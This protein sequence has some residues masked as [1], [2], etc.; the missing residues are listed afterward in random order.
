MKERKRTHNSVENSGLSSVEARLQQQRYGR[1]ILTSA[2]KNHLLTSLF[3][4]VREPMFLLLAVACGLYFFLGDTT[5][6]IMMLVS[7]A[8]VAGIELFQETKSEKAME[9]LREYTE[10]NVRVLRDNVWVEL[11]AAELVPDDLVTIGEG[12]RVP[13]DG[14]ILKQ[15]DFFVE[16]AVLTG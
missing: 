1:N 15:N 10:A 2:K 4:I 13:A 6:A 14:I 16:E 7:I 8:F 5:E 9:A 3:N 11:P 12:E